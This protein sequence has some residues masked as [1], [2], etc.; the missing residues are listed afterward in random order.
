MK[1]KI[2]QK[3]PRRILLISNKVMH[4]RVSVYNY[5]ARRFRE[6]GYWFGVRADEL[7]AENQ[8]KIQ[9]D[10]RTIPFRTSL[11]RREINSLEP[12]FVI[13]FLH[14][15]D[16]MFWPL[17]HWLKLRRIKTLIWTKGA[18]LD[19][20]DNF[21]KNIIFH[22]VHTLADGIVLYSA[23]EMG[24]I[25]PRNRDKVTVAPNTINHE[26][27]PLIAD[28]V[29]DIKAEFGVPFEKIVLFVGR[30][31][32]GG[33]RKKVDH[34]IEIFR[35]E[36]R[37]DVGLVVVGSGMSEWTR[38][39]INP[40][41][42]IYLGEVHDPADVQ[43][44]KIFKMADVFC[45]PGHVGLGLNQAFF[46]GLPV[47]TE[48]GKQ[49]PEIH[50]L[51]DGRNGY[52]VPENDIDQLRKRIFDLLDNGDLRAQLSANAKKDAL[53]RASVANMFQ[54]FL[55]GVRRLECPS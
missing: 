38:S 1:S 47:V 2:N 23:D 20:P 37:P 52:I 24:Y 51:I 10:F 31:D 30:M 4:Y 50:Y 18:N 14:L 53:E 3:L 25:K 32:V 21:L 6:E 33:G 36:E 19:D 15:K 40:R 8:Y 5:F 42:T 16:L 48:Q 22:Y 29:T 39:R 7:Q 41:T 11:Y 44:S 9:F 49:P 26:T 43:I 35:N 12:D 34:L 27:I 54:G 17:L 55:Q 13:L 45:I 28:R 46:W